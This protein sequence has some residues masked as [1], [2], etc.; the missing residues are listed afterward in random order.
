LNGSDPTTA[1]PTIDDTNRKQGLGTSKRGLSARTIRQNIEFNRGSTTTKTPSLREWVI[2]F[3][4]KAE[5]LHGYE[6]DI[7]ALETER[8]FHR[9]QDQI[10]DELRALR[11]TATLFEFIESDSEGAVQVEIPTFNDL[12]FITTG[13]GSQAKSQVGG[14]I[15]VRLEEMLEH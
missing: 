6:F 2:L 12:D 8:L 13:A 14:L 4:K 5:E 7:D 3:R 1:G 10:R 11:R 9:G 15:Q